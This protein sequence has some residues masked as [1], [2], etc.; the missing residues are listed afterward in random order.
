MK[1]PGRIGP[2]QSSISGCA[3]VSSSYVIDPVR[4][5]CRG[6]FGSRGFALLIHGQL[7]NFLVCKPTYVERSI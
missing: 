6:A 5:R 2:P 1:S 4:Q 3:V 7:Q